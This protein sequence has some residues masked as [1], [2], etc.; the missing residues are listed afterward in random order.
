M[1][2]LRVSSELPRTDPESVEKEI[3]TQPISFNLITDDR[4]DTKFQDKWNLLRQIF[5]KLN[6]DGVY[7][8]EHISDYHPDVLKEK[9]TLENMSRGCQFN[10]DDMTKKMTITR[11]KCSFDLFDTLVFRVGRTLDSIFRK[12]SKITEIADFVEKRRKAEQK[13]KQKTLSDIYNILAKYYSWTPAQTQ[14]QQNLELSLEW[15]ALNPI[16]ENVRKVRHGDVIISDMYLPNDFLSR[17]VREKCGLNNPVVSSYDGKWSG[18]IWKQVKPIG[19]HTGDNQISDCDSPNKHGIKNSKTEISNYTHHE[20]Y[21]VDHDQEKLANIC[22]YARLQCPYDTG[23]LHDVFIANTQYNIPCI[24]MFMSYLNTLSKKYSKILFCSRDC[25]YSYYVYRKLYP[26]DNCSLFFSSRKA[27]YS[28]SQE[29]HDYVNSTV[30]KNSL[31]VDMNGTGK[32]FHH[33]F[34]SVNRK[35]VDIIFLNQLIGEIKDNN[36][37]IEMMNYVRFG[38]CIGMTKY[39]QTPT[40]TCLNKQIPGWQNPDIDP[41]IT[42]LEYPK[43]LAYPVEES[44]KL[45]LDYINKYRNDV[46]IKPDFPLLKSYLS[47]FYGKDGD[48][49]EM[50]LVYLKENHSQ[51]HKKDDNSYGYNLLEF[52]NMFEKGYHNSPYH[53]LDNTPIYIINREKD[54]ERLIHMYELLRELGCVDTKKVKVVRPYPANTETIRK[55]AKLMDIEEDRV[56]STPTRA[57][58]SLTYLSILD[59]APENSILVLE[60]DIVPFNS[61]EDTKTLLKFI[62]NNSPVQADMVYLEYCLEICQ[63]RDR[64]VFHELKM[65]SCTA[66]I[67]FPNRYNRE[68]IMKMLRLYHLKHDYEATDVSLSRAVD[69]GYINAYEHVPLFYQ[70]KNYGSFIEGSK[71]TQQPFCSNRKDESLE[72]YPTTNNTSVRYGEDRSGMIF[73]LVVIVV[74]VLLFLYF[75]FKKVIKI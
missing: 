11:P 23:A 18:Y 73:S 40:S 47:R 19:L 30:P 29:Y 44:I 51:N 4:S 60:D 34:D 28:P 17:I 12:Q 21:L 59:Q 70:D 16:M 37:I 39:I 58:H 7:I 67:Y 54:T 25:C 41:V 74:I 72:L 14:V 55:L 56:I 48:E 65:P 5:H 35:D 36:D 38:S 43:Y 49:P 31:V 62:L 69:K 53:N 1:A 10:Y 22:R 66:G 33:Y 15:H 46:D 20:K 27:Y 9:F 61:L 6:A 26:E 57:S 45:V 71:D 42:F 68:K 13:S 32:S 3:A 75:R 2:S 52:L 63:S 64:Q 24:L 50:A 8:I